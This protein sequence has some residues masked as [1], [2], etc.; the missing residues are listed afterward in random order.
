MVTREKERHR[1]KTR[2]KMSKSKF[3]K[4]YGMVKGD[5]LPG[6]LRKG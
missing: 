5:G 3:S 4:W 1:G 6:Y 2:E